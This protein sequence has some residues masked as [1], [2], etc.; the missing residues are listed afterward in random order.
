MHDVGF[1]HIALSVTNLDDSIDFY[2]TYASFEVVHRRE[3]VV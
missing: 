2:A 1:T 3:G